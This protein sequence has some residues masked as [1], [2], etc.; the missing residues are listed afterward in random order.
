MHEIPST[1]QYVLEHLVFEFRYCFGFRISR[2]GFYVEKCYFTLLNGVVVLSYHF[3]TYSKR[4]E[5]YGTNRIRNIQT[6]TKNQL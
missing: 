6:L 4:K 1:N 2:F 3:I 5:Y